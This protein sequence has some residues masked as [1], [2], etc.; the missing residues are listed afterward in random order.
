[1]LV[2]VLFF[3]SQT[4]QKKKK[5][6]RKYIDLSV[7]LHDRNQ[8]IFIPMITLGACYGWN[9]ALVLINGG[10]KTHEARF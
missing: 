7:S 6:L 4:V 3:F 10:I 8:R 9:N 1:M 5:E 2:L